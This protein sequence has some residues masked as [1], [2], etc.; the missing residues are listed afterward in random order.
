M[1]LLIDECL[2]PELTKLAYA[3]GYGES[4]LLA[5]W[6]GQSRPPLA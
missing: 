6:D 3:A 1:K 4:C 2:S 5:V